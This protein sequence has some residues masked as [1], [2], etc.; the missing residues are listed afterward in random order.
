MARI[1]ALLLIGLALLVVL[2][3]VVSRVS[4]SLQAHRGTVWKIVLLVA[5]GAAAFWYFGN[6]MVYDYFGR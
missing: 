4:D 1:A 3:F 6:G 2:V 5:I